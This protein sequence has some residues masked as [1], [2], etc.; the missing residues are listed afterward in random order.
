M[1]RTGGNAM[2]RDLRGMPI[3]ISFARRVVRLRW[4]MLLGNAGWVLVWVEGGKRVCHSNSTTSLSP[5]GN[6]KV[7]TNG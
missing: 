2:A 4:R 1:P 7:A 3:S 5:S 6:W